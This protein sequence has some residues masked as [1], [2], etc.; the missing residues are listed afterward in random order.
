MCDASMLLEYGLLGAFDTVALLRGECSALINGPTAL[1]SESFDPSDD[2]SQSEH[3]QSSSA[4]NGMCYSELQLASKILS[5]QLKLRFGVQQGDRVL[6]S[7]DGNTAAE[8]AAMLACIRLG[9]IFVPLD[10]G[11]LHSGSRLKSIVRQHV[12]IT[13][14]LSDHSVRAGRR[15]QTSSG[16]S[17]W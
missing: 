9:A 1:S 6:I 4:E 5:C 13:C 7:C 3:S 17:C 16:C 8:I 2:S 12:G 10:Y 11:W 15:R 14:L